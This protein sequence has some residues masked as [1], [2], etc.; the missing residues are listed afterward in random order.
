MFNFDFSEQESA[1]PCLYPSGRSC[2][3]LKEEPI[4]FAVLKYKNMLS[5]LNLNQNMLQNA[6][7]KNANSTETL[8]PP[9]DLINPFVVNLICSNLQQQKS[10]LIS[11]HF[12]YFNAFF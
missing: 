4:S 10:N 5:S 3:G 11:K 6:L 8:G 12:V 9:A 7:L 1:L 2:A